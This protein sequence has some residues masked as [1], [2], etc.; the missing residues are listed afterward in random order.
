MRKP[1]SSAES[2]PDTGEDAIAS[3]SLVY[4]GSSAFSMQLKGVGREDNKS[5]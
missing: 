1:D 2:L 4:W 3:L 5:S